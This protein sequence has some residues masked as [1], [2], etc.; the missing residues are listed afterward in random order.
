MNSCI[1]IA[2]VV[3]KPQLRHTPDGLERAEMMIQIS[4]LRAED[5]PAILRAVSWGNLAK[6]VHQTYDKGSQVVVEGRLGMITVNRPEGFKE[7]VAELTIQKI[8]PIGTTVN[9]ADSVSAN[10][11]IPA[12]P[13]PTYTAPRTPEPSVPSYEPPRPVATTTASNNNFSSYEAPAPSSS[14]PAYEPKPYSAP[15]ISDNDIDDIPF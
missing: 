14:A 10:T 1:L 2:Q 4:G 11:T 9:Y 7:K 13:A 5:P 8:Y 3:D 12:T 15:P 6:D